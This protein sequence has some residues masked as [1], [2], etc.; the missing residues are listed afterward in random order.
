[1]NHFKLGELISVSR[2]QKQ[3]EERVF[4]ADLGEGYEGRYVTVANQDGKV[5][6]KGLSDELTFYGWKYAKEIKQ[7]T[8]RPLT[9]SEVPFPLRIHRKIQCS[10]EWFTVIQ[11][12]DE[13]V[14]VN[15]RGH[16]IRLKFKELMN[17][18]L[19]LDNHKLYVEEV[20]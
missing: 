15:Q 18:W 2:N 7:P 3:W 1:M 9:A 14:W 5:K 16:D 20:E 11:V 19:A 12:E 8:R 10:R 4:I 17:H 6:F 13:C